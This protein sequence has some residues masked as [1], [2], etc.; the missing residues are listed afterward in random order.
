MAGQE[1]VAE[2]DKLWRVAGGDEDNYDDH[3]SFFYLAFG[4]DVAETQV[5]SLIVGLLDPWWSCK[6]LV[7]W[8]ASVACRGR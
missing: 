2:V 1:G 4:Q 7:C 5:A 3:D 6:A 8:A